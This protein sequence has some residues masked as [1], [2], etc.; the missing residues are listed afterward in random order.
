MERR[1]II[2]IV[3]VFLGISIFT[4]GLTCLILYVPISGKP[5]GGGR[6]GCFAENTVVWTKNESMPDSSATQVM[7][8]NVPEGNLVGTLDLSLKNGDHMF[9]WTRATDVT[10]YEG[11]WRAHNFTFS[12]GH[13]VTATSPHLM[14]VKQDKEFYF[15]R[16][17]NVQIGDTMLVNGLES[18]IS[19][20]QTFQMN[21]KVSIETEEGT[22][23]ANGI[24]ASGLCEDNPDVIDRIVLA[25]SLV[26]DYKVNHFGEVFT[27]MCM[28]SASWQ[29]AYL[30]NNKNLY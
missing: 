10:I 28:D 9:M 3:C 25:D 1:T 21:T 29:T 11:Q 22:I 2:I 17:D 19:G 8:K 5:T 7:V 12:N 20:I 18:R 16:A 30:V 13:H 15:R 14:M 24:L 6:F 27:E 23:Q 4:A 26:R